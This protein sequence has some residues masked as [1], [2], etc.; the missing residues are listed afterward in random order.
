[1]IG[2]V[3]ILLYFLS[4]LKIVICWYLLLT[5]KFLPSIR[6]NFSTHF[7]FRFSAIMEAKLMQKKTLFFAYS[8][9]SMSIFLTLIEKLLSVEKNTFLLKKNDY[10]LRQNKVFY[11]IL[12][13]KSV[14]SCML[15]GY[16]ISFKN[17]T[18]LYRGRMRK[19]IFM[20][21]WECIKWFLN[22]VTSV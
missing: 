19:N 10:F 4:I 11:T 5:R 1:M 15:L 14:F 8:S 13:I 18:I 6:T 9:K 21:C 17:W 20:H 16:K 12:C 22:I 2:L 3:S 7:S